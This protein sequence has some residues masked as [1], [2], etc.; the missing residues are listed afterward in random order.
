[1]NKPYNYGYSKLKNGLQAPKITI[2]KKRSDAGKKRSPNKRKTRIIP[3]NRMGVIC[4]SRDNNVGYRSGFDSTMTS[5]WQEY[6]HSHIQTHTP[7]FK[8]LYPSGGKSTAGVYMGTL[9]DCKKCGVPFL[10]TTLD[11]YDVFIRRVG[12][13]MAN[14]KPQFHS[15]DFSP[16]IEVTHEILESWSYAIWH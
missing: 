2:R 3:T 8:S 14:G 10:R 11:S 9:L 6:P 12:N 5:C 4:S 13:C 7:D 16:R 15:R 1:M